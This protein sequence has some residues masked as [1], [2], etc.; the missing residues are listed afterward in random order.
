MVN[1]GLVGFGKAGMAV[2]DVLA[3]DPR[4]NLR[5]VARRQADP[6][7]ESVALAGQT[8]PVLGLANGGLEAW[9]DQH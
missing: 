6:S 7:G 4:Y 5:W 1:I 9:L 8:V 3:A 2:A